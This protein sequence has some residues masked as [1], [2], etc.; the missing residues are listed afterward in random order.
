MSWEAVTSC[1]LVVL[2][3]VSLEV[4]FRAGLRAGAQGGAQSGGQVGAIQGA[5]LGLLGL[6]L[7]FSFAGAAS[8]F[9][10]RQDLIVQEANAIGTAYL[11]AD[12]LDDPYRSALREQLS[13]YLEHRIKA[14]E[15]LRDGVTPQIQAEV[16]RFHDAIWKAASD[17]ARAKPAAMVVV[18]PPVNDVI[19]L[20]TTRVAAGRKHLPALVLGLLV[21][22][23][24]MS[25]AV[26]GYGWGLTGR[27][28]PVMTA[29][30]ALLIAAALWTTI[31]LD[32]TRAGLLQVSDVPLKELKLSAPG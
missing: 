4:G 16:A 2:M 18:L 23:S 17:G 21:A 7:G 31:D 27:R 29:V 3:L 8:R 26:I 25:I 28:S 14:S 30:L 22:C 6:L 10:E 32:Y 5:T 19:D 9:I 24:A 12:M 15:R 11:R 20:H 1:G 13:R